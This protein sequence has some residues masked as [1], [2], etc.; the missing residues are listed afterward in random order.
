MVNLAHDFACL[1]SYFPWFM[2]A[3]GYSCLLYSSIIMVEFYIH[4]YS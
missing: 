2:D 1:K 4:E 3:H